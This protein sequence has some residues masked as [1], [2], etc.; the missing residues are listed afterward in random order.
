MAGIRVGYTFHAGDLFHVG[1]LWQLQQSFRQ[2]DFLIVGV[3]TDRALASYK[4]TP[5]MPYAWRAAIYEELRCVGKVVPQN[6]RD[7]TDN[8]KT[9]RPDVLFHGDDWD[10]FP[11]KEWMEAH[12]KEAVMTPYFHGISTTAIIEAIKEAEL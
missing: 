12:G 10:D 1:H 11:G 6:S 9:Y 7:P 5:F 2:C 4:R 8:L 3:L